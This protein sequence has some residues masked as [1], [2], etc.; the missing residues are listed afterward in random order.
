MQSVQKHTPDI[1][2]APKQATQGG[3]LSV[4]TLL[5]RIPEFLCASVLALL[6]IFLVASVT[7][8]Y[9]WDMG[10]PWSDELARMLF[11]WIVFIGFAIAVRHRANVG[12]DYLVMQL[13]PARR[14]IAG[15]FQDVAVLGF[16]IFFTWQSW[17]TVGFSLMQRMPALEITIAWLH[18]SSL[19][20]G[21]LMIIYGTANLV[22]TI[23]GRIPADHFEVLQETTR[24]E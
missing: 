16:A 17:I 19:A 24:I 2:K 1:G 15:L 18:G 6:M 10:L 4:M 11:V 9:V 7:S 8:R 20:A 14:R 23:K 5:L 22:D 12:V 21:I 3:R 13:S